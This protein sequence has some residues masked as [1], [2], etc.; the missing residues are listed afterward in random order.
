MI[1]DPPCCRVSGPGFNGG[2]V[3]T[4]L[5]MT[6]TVHDANGTELSEPRL[7]ITVFLSS[8]CCNDMVRQAVVQKADR[9][10]YICEYRAPAEKGN[11]EL[12]IEINGYPARGS[13][14]PIFLVQ[15][16]QQYLHILKKWVLWLILI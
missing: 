3:R 13:P 2:T 15:I 6:L 9:I 11:Y 7:N 5:R 8:P 4:T 14:C 10:T 1:V 12:H 16:R